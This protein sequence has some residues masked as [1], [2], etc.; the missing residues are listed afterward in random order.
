MRT[1]MPLLTPLLVISL[2]GT[3]RAQDKPWDLAGQVVS[4]EDGEEQPVKLAKVT[5][6]VRDFLRSGRTDN[7]GL[8]VMQLPADAKHGQEVVFLHDKDNYEIFHPFRGAQRLPA[9]GSPP[10]FIEIRMLPKGSKRWL[11]DKLIDV[12]T[13]YERSRSAERLA[14]KAGGRFDFEASLRELATYTGVG[15]QETRKQL[16]AYIDKFREDATN[17]HRQAN[18][19]FLAHNYSLAGEL[20]LKAAGGA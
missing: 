18:A 5:V 14:G 4:I 2:F 12:H 11:S 16:T 19:E 9:Q 7:R 20:Y 10:P 15:E 13:E 17:R 8:F 3:V 1:A 6:T